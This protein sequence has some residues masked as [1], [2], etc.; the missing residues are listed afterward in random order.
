MKKVLLASLVLAII[1]CGCKKGELID[2]NDQELTESMKNFFSAEYD[3]YVKGEHFQVKLLS[4]AKVYYEDKVIYKYSIAIA[5]ML[6]EKMDIYSFSLSLDDEIQ[7]YYQDGGLTS[8]DRFAVQLYEKGDLPVKSGKTEMVA[9]RIE[10]SLDNITNKNQNE[11]GYTEEEFDKLVS[12][13]NITIK[14]NHRKEAITVTSNN[15][16]TIKSEADIPTGRIDLYH[17]LNER[18][19]QEAVAGI[20]DYDTWGY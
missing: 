1:L 19:F 4:L 14:Y 6:D 2:A 20:F 3:D 11:Y 7:K 13:L 16:I 17:Y 12:R 8:Y 18:V 9:Y 10:I 15:I 5:P